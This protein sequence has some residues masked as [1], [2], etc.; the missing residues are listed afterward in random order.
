MLQLLQLSHAPSMSC[1]V[2]LSCLLEALAAAASRSSTYPFDVRQLLLTPVTSG[3]CDVVPPSTVR[4]HVPAPLTSDHRSERSGT[5]PVH[6][7]HPHRA[8]RRCRLLPLRPHLAHHRIAAV[9]GAAARGLLGFSLSLSALMDRPLSLFLFDPVTSQ[10]SPPLHQPH[11]RYP[12]APVSVV[13]QRLQ[14]QGRGHP[15][16]HT[17]H[18]GA[19]RARQRSVGD[20]RPADT[21]TVEL[22]VGNQTAAVEWTGIDVLNDTTVLMPHPSRIPLCRAAV[23]EQLRG[24]GA[25]RRL[26]PEE[27]VAADPALSALLQQTTLH[28]LHPTPLTTNR[29][30]VVH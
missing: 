3:T 20:R 12:A 11:H 8:G 29:Q 23:T 19:D 24:P 15:R 30:R 22:L 21:G 9:G 26:Q 1:L 14:R 28:L 25:G 2:R 17:P 27:L 5:A 16:L 10:Q 6:A 7:R 13:H 4:C 18:C